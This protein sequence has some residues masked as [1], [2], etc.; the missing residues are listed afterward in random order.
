[1]TALKRFL[2]NARDEAR[3]QKR[4]GGQ[5]VVSINWPEA[6]SR[7]GLEV[8]HNQTAERI[9]E[10]QWARALLDR[11]LADLNEEYAAAGKRQLFEWISRSL[12]QPRGAV[13]YATIAVQLN[14]SEAAIK[15]AVQRLRARYRERLRAE[16]AHTVSGPD[17]IEQEIRYLFAT[18]G[19]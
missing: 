13:P 3:A 15:M 1:L 8:G 5:T 4:G 12:S 10:R 17:E 14:T 19:D 6:E 7:L 18:F 9:Y 16:I 11:V 2:A